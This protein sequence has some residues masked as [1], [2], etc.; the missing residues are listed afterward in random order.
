MR[1][2][3]PLRDSR[4]RVI[5][6]VLVDGLAG[7]LW[8]SGGTQ[9]TAV[10]VTVEML[11][12]RCPQEGAPLGRCGGG[13]RV[14]SMKVNL[15]HVPKPPAASVSSSLKWEQLDMPRGATRSLRTAVGLK[16]FLSDP[17]QKSSAASIH[18]A[19]EG[20]R[21]LLLPGDNTGRGRRRTRACVGWF[22]FCKERWETKLPKRACGCLL[23]ERTV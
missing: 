17:L 5:G 19:V 16:Y 3:R 20:P 6:P 23:Q 10:C 4:A 7:C 14:Q 13:S 2:Y 18:T 21:H 1:I 9:H 15:G 22:L 11:P 12:E 8:F